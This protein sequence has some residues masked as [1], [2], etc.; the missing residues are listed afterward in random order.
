MLSVPFIAFSRILEAVNLWGLRADIAKCIETVDRSTHEWSVPDAFIHA[1]VAAEDRR[2]AMHF[3]IDPLGMVRAL[4]SIV[5]GNGIQGASTI[6]QQFARVVTKCYERTI[7]R[8]IREQAIA[9][10]VSRRRSKIEIC[11][12]Y[13]S[14]AFYGQ[15]LVGAA[16]ISTLCGNV[17]DSCPAR[18]VHEAIARLKYPQ[19]VRPTSLWNIKI[20]N[21]A[22]YIARNLPA[23]PKPYV[24]SSESLPLEP[25][26]VTL[27]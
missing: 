20:E 24:S 4:L 25:V 5:T 15:G 17:L 12:A 22:D 8:K 18:K 9:I 14:I 16:G 10:A 3:G 21:R 19:P 7:F 11:A 13:L 23:K 2:N 1:L 6:E 26:R 27:G